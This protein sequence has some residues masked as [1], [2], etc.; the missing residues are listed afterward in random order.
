MPENQPPK[1]GTAQV[2]PRSFSTMLGWLD[3]KEFRLVEGLVCRVQFTREMVA[4]LR[5][6]DTIWSAAGA[7]EHRAG[8]SRITGV[9]MDAFRDRLD[10]GMRMVLQAA[11]DLGRRAGFT[12]KIRKNRRILVRNGLDVD[13]KKKREPAPEVRAA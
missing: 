4:G 3:P 8:V 1:P 12:E 2:L 9:E 7:A 10:E 11:L 5:F 13:A 6:V